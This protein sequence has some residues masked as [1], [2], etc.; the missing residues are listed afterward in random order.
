MTF[1]FRTLLPPPLVWMCGTLLGA[2]LAV[3]IFLRHDN[4]ASPSPAGENLRL[5]AGPEGQR[6][7]DTVLS[8]LEGFRHGTT[9]EFAQADQRLR[10]T[11]RSWMLADPRGCLRFLAQQR[12]IGLLDAEFIT[13]IVS[14]MNP[15]DPLRALRFGS[16]IDDATTRDLWT[17]IAFEDVTRRDCKTAFD[18]LPS[19]PTPLRA[20]LERAL[21]EEWG[22]RDGRT[23]VSQI[24]T[25]KGKGR[26]EAF[27]IALQ[28][29]GKVAALPAIEFA[30][31]LN[32]GHPEDDSTTRST[33]L[34]K[35]P[36]V[37]RGVAA[38]LLDRLKRD[39]ND[40][41]AI[42]NLRNIFGNWAAQDVEAAATWADAISSDAR[43]TALRAQIAGL[44][45]STRPEEAVKMADQLPLD[46][47]RAQIYQ[48]ATIAM[49]KSNPE[50]AFTW[51][52]E[53]ASPSLRKIAMITSLNYAMANDGAKTLD[54]ALSPANAPQ[55]LPVV[56]Q[57]LE[58]S[59]SVPSAPAANGKLNAPALEKVRATIDRVA[60]D[61]RPAMLETV[62]RYEK[63]QK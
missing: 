14:A 47:T 44:L 3:S 43:K 55:W 60:P 23:A 5:S 27:E 62:A 20:D 51:S 34:D 6:F 28:A 37:V 30:L 15:E 41:I 21:A 31:A 50:R 54:L 24:S 53:I 1:R 38:L 29:W 33:L 4:V 8:L 13:E 32:S 17:K 19:V 45:A 7:Q 22:R 58:N 52:A 36:E 26:N 61:Q 57:S 16:E 48:S 63:Q 11:I 59:M 46:R 2:L 25:H 12:C 49:T 40:A 56:L 35:H 9:G 42:Y 39:P 18:A 10:E